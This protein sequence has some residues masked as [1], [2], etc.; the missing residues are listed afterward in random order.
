MRKLSLKKVEYLEGLDGLQ[1]TLLDDPLEI[2]NMTK[3]YRVQHI[4]A[5][6]PECSLPTA[7][8]YE[9]VEDGVVRLNKIFKPIFIDRKIPLLSKEKADWLLS[10]ELGYNAKTKAAARI[11]RDANGTVSHIAC[12]PVSGE[13]YFIYFLTAEKWDTPHRSPENTHNTGKNN[14]F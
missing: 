11:F 2:M 6:T 1:L 13:P 5:D 14:E 9:I 3:G 12:Y 7:Y 4:L 10:T 8:P